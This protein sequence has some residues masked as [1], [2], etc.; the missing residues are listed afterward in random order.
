MG[1]MT[2]S[3]IHSQV[4]QGNFS[5]E[6]NDFA[7]QEWTTTNLETELAEKETG[8]ECEFLWVGREVPGLDAVPAQ[9]HSADVLHPSH[10]IFARLVHHHTS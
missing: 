7:F 1:E 6:K 9:L 10:H 4:S 3:G 8:E 2:S 5:H